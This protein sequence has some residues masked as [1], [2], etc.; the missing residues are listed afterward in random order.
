MAAF[1]ESASAVNGTDS[2]IRFGLARSLAAVSA[3][4][5]KVT[6]SKPSRRS[7]RS[8]V[9]PMTSCSEPSGSSSDSII[10][11]TTAWVR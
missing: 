1:S 3:E 10:S 5:V 4:P 8:P 6:A 7:S 11:L 2:R 9:L